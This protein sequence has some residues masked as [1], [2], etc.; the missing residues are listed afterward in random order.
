MVAILFFCLVNSQNFLKN[1]K[2]II[3][4]KFME[5]EVKKV[6][7]PQDWKYDQKITSYPYLHSND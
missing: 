3:F 6:G 2:I 1:E 7:S 4:M 5:R